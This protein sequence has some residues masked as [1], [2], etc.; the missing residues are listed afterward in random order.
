[1]LLVKMEA[2]IMG[3][4]Y[5]TTQA[6]IWLA[7]S[8]YFIPYVSFFCRRCWYPPCLMKLQEIRLL[9]CMLEWSQLLRYWHKGWVTRARF[10]SVWSKVFSNGFKLRVSPCFSAIQIETEAAGRGLLFKAPSN[11]RGWMTYTTCP[12]GYGSWGNAH[13]ISKCST[14]RLIWAATA[15]RRRTV[16]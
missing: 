2:V 4:R 10:I 12:L 6:H 3:S 14:L 13:L 7:Q 1:M 5:A 11:L 9:I 8:Y 16:V 15:K